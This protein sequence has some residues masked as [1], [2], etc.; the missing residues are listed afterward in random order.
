MSLFADDII[1]YT[2]NPQVSSKTLLELRMNLGKFHDIKSIYKNLLH[3]YDLTGNYHKEKLRNQTHLQ[4]H[5]K[6]LNT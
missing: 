5:Q 6:E 1:S 3:F 2:E 4:L